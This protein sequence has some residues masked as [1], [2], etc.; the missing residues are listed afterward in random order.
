[1][2]VK[3]IL[4][5]FWRVV[6]RG[7]RMYWFPPLPPLPTIVTLL[8]DAVPPKLLM[9]LM[10]DGTLKGMPEILRRD[11]STPFTRRQSGRKRA[12]GTSPM[13]VRPKT[14]AVPLSVTSADCLSVTC[15]K[16]D[17]NAP[18]FNECKVCFWKVINKLATLPVEMP[19]V[20]SVMGIFNCTP[21]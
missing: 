18:L 2:V 3:L 13:A 11:V 8:S 1:L 5:G 14:S 10:L 17:P 7:V 20:V 12:Y 6:V 21:K 16:K 15:A 19:L 4:D 9:P